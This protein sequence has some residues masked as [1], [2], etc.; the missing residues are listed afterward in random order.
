MLSF[1]LIK[2]ARLKELRASQ[3]E[4]KHLLAEAASASAFI[5]KIGQGSLDTLEADPAS[6]VQEHQS[7]LISSLLGMR[8][9]MKL[10]ATKEKER[11]W[12]T[13]GLARFVE[14]LRSSYDT[15]EHLYNNILSNLIT[16]VSANQ[17]GLFVVQEESGA[18]GEETFIDLVA[19]YAYD[20][21]KYLEKRIHAGEGLVGQCYLETQTVYMTAVPEKYVHITSGLGEAPPRSLLI[22]PLKLDGKVYGIV[23]LASFNQMERYQIEFIEKL[24]ESI[25]SAIA[26]AQI[27]RRT[28]E[29]LEVSQVQAEQLRASEEEIRQNM[30]EMQATQEEVVR[31]QEIFKLD[32]EQKVREATEEVLGKQAEMARLLEKFNLVTQTTTEGVWDMIVPENLEFKDHTPFQWADRFRQMLGYS[33]EQ[34]FPN[35]LDSWANLLHPDHKQRT[36]AAF[37]AHLLDFS[38]HTPYDVEYLLKLKDGQYKWFRAV[39][40]TLRD[41]HGKPKRVAGTLIDIQALKDLNTF[42]SELEQKIRERTAEVEGL[43]TASQEQTELLRASEERMRYKDTEMTG[44]FTAINTTLATVEMDMDGIILTANDNFLQLMGYTL[45]EIRGKHHS[46]L[47]DSAYA[48]S[49]PYSCFWQDLRNGIAQI[50]DF[51]RIT[52]KGGQVWMQA[53][54]T[55]VLDG[56]GKPYKVIKMAQDITDKKKAEIEAHKLSLVA[57]NTDNSVI[58]TDKE[59]CIEYVNKGFERLSGYTLEEMKGRKPGSFLQGPDTDKA[60]VARIRQHL[61]ERKPFYEEIINYTKT[62]RLYWI[63]LSINPVFGADGQLERFVAVQTDI[64]TTKLEALEFNSKL[65]AID[66]SNG[67]IEFDV[68]GN[69]LTANDVLLNLMGY[70]LEEIRGKHHRIFVSQQE[71]NSEVYQQFWNQ[72]ATSGKFVSGEFSR[73]TKSGGQLWLR[74]SYN[75]VFD[76]TGRPFKVFKIA[77][78]ITEQKVLAA[79]LQSHTEELRAQEEELRQNMEE[80]ETTQEEMRRNM[81]ETANLR[82]ELAARMQVLD[83]SAMLTESD[84][85]GTI[86]YVNDKFCEVSKWTREEVMGKPHSIVRHPDNPASLYKG[87]WATLKSGGIFKGQFRN[88]AKDGTDYWVDSTIAPVL[89]AEGQTVKYIGIRYDI[90]HQM[91]QY[92]KVNELLAGADNLTQELRAQEE[93]LRQNME[94]LH[95]IQEETERK[96]IELAGLVAA[97]NSTLATIM[98]DMEGIILTANDNFLKIMDYTLNEIQGKHHSLFV[99]QKY[100]GSK[101]YRR[102]WEKL[103]RGQ[104]QIGE[105]DRLTRNG[106]VVRLSASYTP[107]LDANGTP[108]KVIKFAQVVTVSSTQQHPVEA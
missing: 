100:A 36:L 103:N 5:Q 98:F 24:G 84:L 71:Q 30:E 93:E 45:D 54:Y 10:I 87:M 89:N 72:F 33:N 19:C 50:S 62:G 44:I 11:S 99:D 106:D 2:S 56:S 108:I 6:G 23:E 21:K 91:T 46:L 96:S 68:K 49:E 61:A 38:G 104:S 34:D 12:A 28:R 25:A 27:S 47:V 97:V 29:L 88:R 31:K 41:E 7:E 66:K 26:S 42:K 48:K 76:T 78:N 94:E 58:I 75:A 39:G 18:Q 52:K 17:G 35:R 73:V 32:L 70:T 15:T 16:Y 65:E 60:T 8:E 86:T 82:A 69:I 55:P 102:F 53:S 13:E 63:S 85:H 83:E 43:L 59:G 9:Q 4:V 79:E 105:V 14:I 40:N 107:A 95:T 22:V 57:D 37:S 67:T 1:T 101:E 64:T 20:R 51:M 90:T 80:M 81:D 74:G 3:Q 92:E 77:Q